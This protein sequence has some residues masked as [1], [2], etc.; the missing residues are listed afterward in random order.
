MAKS[1]KRNELVYLED[2]LDCI[3]KIE[4]YMEGTTEKEFESNSQ[5]AGCCNST[6]RD[7]W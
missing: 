3:D 6:H 1:N 4:E 7:N 2:V 5:E